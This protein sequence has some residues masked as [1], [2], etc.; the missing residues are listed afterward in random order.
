MCIDFQELSQVTLKDKFPILVIDELFDKIHG[1]K[2]FS[3]LHLRSGYH[4]IRIKEIDTHKTTFRTHESH[5]ELLVIP[6]GLTNAHSTFQG[7]INE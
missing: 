7:L 2:M 6:F 5:Y 1:A 4:Q 3:K